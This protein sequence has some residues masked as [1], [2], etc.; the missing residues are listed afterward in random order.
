MYG[1]SIINR[2]D[3]E[4]D[5]WFHNTTTQFDTCY[6]CGDME[7][8]ECNEY[9]EL[10]M[11]HC[12]ECDEK[13]YCEKCIPETYCETWCGIMNGGPFCSGC[14]P[15][16]FCSNCENTFCQDCGNAR[17]VTRVGM[18]YVVDVG[19]MTSISSEP[20]QIVTLPSAI[21]A[22]VKCNIVKHTRTATRSFAMIVSLKIGSVSGVGMLMIIIIIVHLLLPYCELL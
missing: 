18:L 3:A 7:C 10:N 6:E 21:S 9:S 5:M 14:K 1:R 16:V 17:N 22:A 4:G 12:Q 19:N 15:T 11:Y 8:R 2:T 13:V 20:V